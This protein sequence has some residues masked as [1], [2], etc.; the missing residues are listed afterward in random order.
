MALMHASLLVAQTL[1]RFIPE[2]SCVICG[3][4]V[5]DDFYLFSDCP[6]A[7]A[8][9]IRFLQ[10]VILITINYSSLFIGRN[11]WSLTSPL[12]L[13]QNGISFF[14][15]SIATFGVIEINVFLKK[16]ASKLID[17]GC[18]LILT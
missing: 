15:L 9:W 2:L 4:A 10:I 14:L 12:L 18:A 3:A 13:D 1:A 8:T 16:H 11:G 17:F 5:E 7:G 6:L